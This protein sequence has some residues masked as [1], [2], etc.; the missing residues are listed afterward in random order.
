MY[1]VRAVKDISTSCDKTETQSVNENQVP[2]LS[3]IVFE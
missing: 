1:V 2:I 3:Q